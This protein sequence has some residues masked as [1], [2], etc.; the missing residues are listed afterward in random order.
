MTKKAQ[1]P[2]PYNWCQR[3]LVMPKESC[4]C[5]CNAPGEHAS[6]VELMSLALLVAAFRVLYNVI[7]FYSLFHSQ[8][9]LWERAFEWRSCLI[10]S[11]SSSPIA[12]PVAP[13]HLWQNQSIWCQ[14]FFSGTTDLEHRSFSPLMSSGTMFRCR[15]KRSTRCMHC[16]ASAVSPNVATWTTHSCQAPP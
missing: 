5:T 15:I 16:T 13:P 3:Q 7:V 10:I 12:F 6:W 4:C 8:A 9:I 1:A 2:L 14:R 11:L